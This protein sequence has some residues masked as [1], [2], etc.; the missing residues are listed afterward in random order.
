MSQIAFS[1]EWLTQFSDPYAVLGLSVSADDRRVLKRYHAIAKHLHPDSF[2]GTD[3]AEAEV[4][5][6]ILS[7]LINPAYQEIKQEKGRAETLARLR[8]RVR[9]TAR[10]SRPIAST[11]Q[12]QS[13]LDAPSHSLD[14]LYEQ[15]IA[16]MADVQYTPLSQFLIITPQLL[17]LNTIYLYIKI[18]APEIREKRTGVIPAVA[19]RPIQYATL[20][21]DAIATTG[22]SYAERH[23]QR[24]REYLKKRNWSMAVQELRDAIRLEPTQGEFHAL[25]AIAYLMQNLPG[26][27]KVH[28]RQALKLDPGNQLAIRY[29]KKLGIE[30]VLPPISSS[31]DSSG[32]QA[33]KP[34]NSAD[35]RK[36]LFGLFGKRQ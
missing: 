4:A 8:M 24:A 36:G 28:C 7:R 16:S 20:S 12:A 13:L 2:G 19:A 35:P 3:T 27:A 1:P 29:A 23:A 32:R 34:S 15:A 6:Q 5:N 31:A 30:V 14:M 22:P 33:S 21:P 10:Q 17:E 18:G 26:M 25:L 11:A 9:D